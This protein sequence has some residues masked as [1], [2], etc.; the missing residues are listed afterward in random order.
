[1]IETPQAVLECAATASASTRLDVLV[2]GTKH[3]AREL[4]ALPVPGADRA[5]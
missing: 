3:L 4:G 1:M 5:R 2:V